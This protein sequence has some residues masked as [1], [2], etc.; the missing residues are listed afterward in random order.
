MLEK[1]L[2][3]LDPLS[4]D[5]V[6]VVNRNLNA[7]LE[8]NASKLQRQWSDLEIV[9]QDAGDIEVQVDWGWPKKT[10]NFL[11]SIHSQTVAT[12]NDIAE[13]LN[14]GGSGNDDWK[15]DMFPILLEMILRKYFLRNVTLD[16]MPEW[17]MDIVTNVLKEAPAQKQQGPTR[18]TVEARSLP[19][20]SLLELY[21][22]LRPSSMDVT[23]DDCFSSDW[24]DIRGYLQLET[25]RDAERIALHGKVRRMEDADELFR[26]LDAA[27]NQEGNKLVLTN[28][29]MNITP[30][31][32]TQYIQ[33]T[34][35]LKNTKFF[36]TFKVNGEL[37][38]AIF[39]DLG[40]WK[41]KISYNDG[42]LKVYP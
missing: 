1:V 29:G 9:A 16:E 35:A 30:Q 13:Y 40:I 19:E 31:T 5:K 15:M 34:I 39:N 10:R 20:K 28:S 4:I 27:R 22:Q 33:E 36:G 17:Y 12:A 7:H 2:T 26:E 6:K 32:A 41:N 8:A 23:F 11:F 24:M 42:E 38:R 21:K 18:L 25:C 14:D 3:K 37:D